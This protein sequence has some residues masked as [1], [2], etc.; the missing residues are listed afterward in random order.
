MN[1]VSTHNWKPELYDDKLGFVSQYGK[2]VIELLAAQ[3]GERI[4]DLGCG[5]GDLSHEIA[6]TGAHVIGMD[7]SSQMLEKARHKYPEVSFVIGNAEQFSLDEP[8]DAVF[9]NAALH[10]VKNAEGAA[11][12]IW[13]VLKDGGRFVAEFG[14]QGNVE[15]IVKAITTVLAE[16]YGLN[17]NQRNPWY[18]PSIGEY[19]SLLERQGFRV[20]YA[21]HFD[22][23]TKLADG[24][25]GLSHWLKGLAA[26]EFFMGFSDSEIDDIFAKVTADARGKLFDASVGSWFADYKRIRIIA[27]K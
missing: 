10:W 26:E 24:E 2:G 11:A 12:S 5:T 7:L 27:V 21:V 17:A 3:E 4:L 20:I 8:M 22:R 13:N 16:S 1:M 9:S 6:Q 15:T 14:G 18:F 19:S 25:Y 23:P